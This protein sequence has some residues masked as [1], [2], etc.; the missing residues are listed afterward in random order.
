MKYIIYPLSLAVLFLAVACGGGEAEMAQPQTLAEA[1]A[2]L[3]TKR[4]ALRDLQKEVDALEATV[5]KLDTTAKREKIVTVTTAPVQVKDFEHFVE[6]QGNVETAEDPAFASSETGG[7]ITSLLVKEGDFVK[8][9]SVIAK[10]NMESLKNSIAELDKSLSLARDIYKR[11]ENLWSQKIGSEVQY[12]QAKNQ[13]EQLE[14][15]KKSLEYELSKATVYAPIS[16]YVDMV[17]VK[18][19]EIAAPGA[20]IVTILNTSKLQVVASIPEVY[21]GSVKK[22][23]VVTVKFPAL[24]EEQRGRVTDISR[25]INSANRTFDIEVSVSN[26]GMLKP[27]L[28]ATVAVR[29]YEQSDAI[30]VPD[31]LIMQDVSGKNYLMTLEG[32]RAKKQIVELGKNFNNETVINSGLSKEATLLMK[33]A[34]QVTDGDKVEIVEEAVPTAEA[35]G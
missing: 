26:D 9:G 33:G 13:V 19:G 20:P 2:A 18:A 28:L 17:R 8:R 4:Q 1:R 35:Q 34:R 11:Q 30:V 10:V 27:N 16:G 31:Q 15:S 6:V 14:Q 25:T 7:R 29:D 5:A 23:E 22:G 12:L 21:L 3:T 32:D 24:G